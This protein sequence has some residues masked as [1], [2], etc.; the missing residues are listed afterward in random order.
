MTVGQVLILGAGGHARAVAAALEAAAPGSVAGF[1]EAAGR[2]Y[3]HRIGAH[4]VVGT[5]DHLMTLF[6][7]GFTKL[8]MGL[9]SIS[10]NSLRA[11]VYPKWQ[12]LGFEWATVIHPAAFLSPDVKIGPGSV[13]MPGAILHCGVTVGVNTIINTGAI[14]DHDC[15]IGDHVH[16]AP[17]VILAGNVTVESRAFIGLGSRIIQGIHVGSGSLVGAG[18]LVLRDV[19]SN[20]RIAG[21][22]AK[23]LD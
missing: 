6:S 9:G 4:P 20:A 17:G 3:G 18:S 8:A 12:A 14:I 10:D 23:P 15:R 16:V 5:D 2:P 7:K 1:I 19:P 21:I 11:K 22:P 13:I